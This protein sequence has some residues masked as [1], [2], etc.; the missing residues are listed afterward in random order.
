MQKISVNGNDFWFPTGFPMVAACEKLGGSS[1][2]LTHRSTCH[3]AG[4][5]G[6]KGG[7]DHKEN[8]TLLPFLAC[9]HGPSSSSEEEG[10]PVNHWSPPASPTLPAGIWVTASTFAHY[11]LPVKRFQMSALVSKQPIATHLSG[12]AA[13]RLGAGARGRWEWGQACGP[14]S[15]SFAPCNLRV[16]GKYS[17]KVRWCRSSH[18]FPRFHSHRS[19]GSL[20]SVS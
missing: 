9:P 6:R 4:G 18:D 13:S 14:F 12:L 10:S 3:F 11:P 16:L 8:C 15:C 7:V 20:H 19:Y 2:Q 5:V 17:W 1:C